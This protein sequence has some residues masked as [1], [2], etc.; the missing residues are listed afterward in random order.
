[1]TSLYGLLYGIILWCNGISYDQIPQAPKDVLKLKFQLQLMKPFS[2]MYDERWAILEEK[3]QTYQC[4]SV[5]DAMLQSL[6]KIILAIDKD[7]KQAITLLPDMQRDSNFLDNDQETEYIEKLVAYKVYPISF[8]YNNF[9]LQDRPIF[10]TPDTFT[11]RVVAERSI[12]DKQFRTEL[13]ALSQRY[14]Q[15]SFEQKSRTKLKYEIE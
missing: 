9:N 4:D 11:A 15:A 8:T 6:Q 1:M 7:E 3:C 12:R 10:D 2:Q 5:S 13:Q 14:Q